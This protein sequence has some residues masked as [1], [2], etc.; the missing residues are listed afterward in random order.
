LMRSRWWLALP[1]A[2]ALLVAEDWLLAGRLADLEGEALPRAATRLNDALPLKGLN[3]NQQQV[4]RT[5]GQLV[6]DQ[7]LRLAPN[8]PLILATGVALKTAGAP[9]RVALIAGFA[10]QLGGLPERDYRDL[11]KGWLAPALADCASVTDHGA[12]LRGIY[13]A[14]H[15]SAFL[16]VYGAALA[17]LPSDGLVHA[18][19]WWLSGG[20]AVPQALLELVL[21]ERLR[22][23]TTNARDDLAQAVIKGQSLKKAARTAWQ[24]LLASA[25]RPPGILARLVERA[26]RL[27]ER[28]DGTRGK[29]RH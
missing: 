27:F 29:D 4:A 13:S 9:D 10:G 6:L 3:Q 21:A 1:D 17:K 15:E 24:E 23:L 11:L 19:R 2:E 25:E 26:G 8:R 14:D 16:E 28:E 20:D 22:K 18:C 12:V 7:N 5:L